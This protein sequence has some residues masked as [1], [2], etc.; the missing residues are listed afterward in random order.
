M[1]IAV[2]LLN[3]KGKKV[4]IS[5]FGELISV[6]GEYDESSFNS[7]TTI[8]TAY[9]FYKPNNGYNFIITGIDAFADKSVSA[10]TN[11][12]FILY[13][14]TNTDVT[15]VSR[16]LYQTELGQ[17]QRISLSALRILCS[18][19]LYINGKCDDNNIHVNI[20]GHFMKRS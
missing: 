14:A 2:H 10:V 4:A 5:D 17:N 13:E 6:P 12:I 18:P 20:F 8:N 7:M 1:S 19:G 3:K 15:T 16:I 11:S 9:N